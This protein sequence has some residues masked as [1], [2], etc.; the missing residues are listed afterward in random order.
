MKVFII[1]KNERAKLRVRQY[2][3][4]MLLL[5]ETSDRFLVKSLGEKKWKGWFS[6]RNGATFEILH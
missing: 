6:K 2:G 3:F 4:S 5:K 1:P